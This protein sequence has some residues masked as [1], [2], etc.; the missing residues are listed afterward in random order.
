MRM[1]HIG[2]TNFY[3]KIYILDCYLHAQD[4]SREST[5]IAYAH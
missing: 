4:I 2:K 3:F 1:I 5:L